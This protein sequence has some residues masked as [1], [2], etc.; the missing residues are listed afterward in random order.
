[1]IASAIANW[2]QW[3]P[4][5]AIRPS[6]FSLPLLRLDHRV[7]APRLNRKQIEKDIRAAFDQQKQRMGG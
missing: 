1:V 3:S 4:E 5:T 2:S 6:D 7:R